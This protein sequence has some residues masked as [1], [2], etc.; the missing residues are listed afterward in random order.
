M[1]LRR[2]QGSPNGLGGISRWTESCLLPSLA[3]QLP[4]WTLL[5][6]VHSFHHCLLFFSKSCY[7]V[8]SRLTSSTPTFGTPDSKKKGI[9]G[10]EW[11][12]ICEKRKRKQKKKGNENEDVREEE[13]EM[14]EN[15][16]KEF[17][18][19]QGVKSVEECT[20]LL[21]LLSCPP[22]ALLLNRQ[23]ISLIFFT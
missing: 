16:N 13:E 20:T 2:S 6:S 7:L 14:E 21:Y 12:K 9:Y 10:R 1:P 22:L 4:S 15:P 8:L 19:F 5:C 23:L 18:S 11:K 3:L 17:S